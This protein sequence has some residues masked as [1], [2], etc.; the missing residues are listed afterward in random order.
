[1]REFV[2]PGAFDLVLSMLTSF[3]YFEDMNENVKV[4]ENIFVSLRE[5][6]DSLSSCEP[7]TRGSLG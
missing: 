7:E 3:G 1:M 6:G 2:R 4:L 5:G